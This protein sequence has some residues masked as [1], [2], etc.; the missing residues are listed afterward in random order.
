MKI[1]QRVTAFAVLLAVTAVI[2][3]MANTPQAAEKSDK[4]LRHVVLV[5][6]KDSATAEQVKE[7]EQLFVGLKKQIDEIEDFEWGTND[8]P[9]G[10]SQGFTHCFLVTFKTEEDRNAYLPHKA[11]LAFVEQAR[12]LF[13]KVLVVDYWAAKGS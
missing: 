13:D 10:L 4:L 2:G 8:S 6:F 9:E 11:H 7:A 3:T 12:P 5:K 1:Q